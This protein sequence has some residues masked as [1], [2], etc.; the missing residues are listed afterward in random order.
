MGG[1]GEMGGGKMGG[2]RGMNTD[3]ARIRPFFRLLIGLSPH[4]H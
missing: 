4:E 2:G 1:G 3:Y